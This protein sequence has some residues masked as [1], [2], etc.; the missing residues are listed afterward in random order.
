[1]DGGEDQNQWPEMILVK[2]DEDRK[3]STLLP[4][5]IFLRTDLI[6]SFGSP[7]GHPPP[8]LIFPY[9]I[10]SNFSISPFLLIL[11]CQQIFFS[12]RYF[13]FLLFF[14][15]FPSLISELLFWAEEISSS[16][17]TDWQLDWK[18]WK[19]ELKIR[20]REGEKEIWCEWD[21][22]FP[23]WHDDLSWDNKSFFPSVDHGWMGPSLI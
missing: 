23:L 13:R 19:R 17:M 8:L 21:D 1:M 6:L 9:I 2:K 15:F 5:A 11:L 7:N 4:A 18:H 22:F 14:S 16:E 10:F 20:G 12:P 3:G